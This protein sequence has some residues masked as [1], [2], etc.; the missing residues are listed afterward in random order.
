[1]GRRSRQ[2]VAL[3][4]AGLMLGGCYGPFY[5]TRRLWKWNGQVSENKWVVEAVH[6]VCLWAPVYGI[7]ALADG[8]IFNSLEFWTG[9][10]PMAPGNA[11]LP[12]VETKRVARNDAE[13]VLTH[14]T[15]QQGE[16]LLIEQYQKGKAAGS[17][18]MRQQNGITVASDEKGDTIFRA[19]TLPDGS[20]LVTDAAGTR[21][22]FYSASQM[23]QLA[24]AS[25]RR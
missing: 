22:A 19:Q 21:V 12:K 10:N 13:A 4:A 14:I 18:R 1:M 23:Q 9:N 25:S 17:V 8:I 3:L 20:M 5:L 7:A 15:S 16:E 2:V 6:L 24:D 11:T